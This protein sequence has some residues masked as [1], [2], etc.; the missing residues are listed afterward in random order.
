MAQTQVADALRRSEEI[1]YMQLIAEA[2]HQAASIPQ[3]RFRP[4][5]SYPGGYALFGSGESWKFGVRRR[6]RY[7]EMVDGCLYPIDFAVT[8]WAPVPDDQIDA[9]AFG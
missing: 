3:P 1:D 7:F 9:Y 5:K 6:G 2:T 8:E 4:I